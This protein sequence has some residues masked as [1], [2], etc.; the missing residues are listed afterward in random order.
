VD[1]M[2]RI[3]FLLTEAL[4]NQAAL[5]DGDTATAKLIGGSILGAIRAFTDADNRDALALLRGLRNEVL[6]LD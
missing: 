5:A 3:V 6:R 4:H 1:P 2:A